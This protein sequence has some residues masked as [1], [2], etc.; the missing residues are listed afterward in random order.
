MQKRLILMLGAGHLF[1]DV[2]QGALPALL[3]FFIAT[4]H[5]SYTT[6]ATLVFAANLMSCVMQPAFGHLTDRMSIPWI[7]PAGIAMAGIGVAL[8]VVVPDYGWMLAVVALSGLAV[9]AFHPEAT[10]LVKFLSGDRKA[11]AMS[12]FAVGGNLGFAVGP[13]LTTAFVGWLGLR[14]G[15]LLSIPG[16]LLAGVIVSRRREFSNL[17][18]AA[19]NGAAEAA[20]TDHWAPFAFLTATMVFRSVVFFGLNTFLA[21]YWI[22][23]LHQSESAGNT[24]LSILMF[25][26]VA[27]ALMGGALA[28]SYG[29]GRIV[30]GSLLLVPVLLGVFLA[31]HQ[32]VVATLLLVPLGLVLTANFSVMIVMAQELLPNHLG[33][34]S[35][36]TLGIGASVGGIAMPLFGRLA[37]RH[38]MHASLSWLMIVATVTAVLAVLTDRLARGVKHVHATAV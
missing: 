27:G 33:V 30:V 21:L 14:G 16:I 9:A 36:V 23:N 25:S 37:D 10:R 7:V 13:L 5:F 6:A 12:W 24:A 17:A 2:S 22:S 34:A 4:H 15:L 26:G 35:G 8:T 11:T 31:M 3:P 1:T 19:A 20:E 29:R 18:P 38:G 32:V 28:D